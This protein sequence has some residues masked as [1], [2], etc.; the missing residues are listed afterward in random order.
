MRKETIR[1][2]ATHAKSFPYDYSS[3]LKE[4]FRSEISRSS[5]LLLETIRNN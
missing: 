2:E 4:G 1:F 3:Y 5:S